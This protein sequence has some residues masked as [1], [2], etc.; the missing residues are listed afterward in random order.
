[1]REL[2]DEIAGRGAEVQAN[3]TRA[4]LQTLFNWAVEQ[5][6]VPSSPVAGLKPVAKEVDR[7]RVL[8]DDEIKWFWQSCD[9]V[10]WPF[11]P[12]FK[13]LLL[14]AQ[15]RD[16]VGTME[17]S[18]IDLD[19]RIWT[20]PRHKAKNNRVHEVQLSDAAI[21]LLGSLP[22][23]AVNSSASDRAGKTT[24]SKFVFTTNG[25]TPVSGFSRAKHRL[26]AIMV[27]VRRKSLNQPEA[28]E[29]HRRAL[30]ITA[31]GPLPGE[32]PAWILHDLRRTTATGMAKLNVPPHVVDK[33]LN[34]VSGAIRGVAAIYNRHGY[35]N[36][37]RDALEEWGRHVSRLIEAPLNNTQPDPLIGGVP[38]NPSIGREKLLSECPK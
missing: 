31:R 14:T 18:E 29:E 32:V 2:L 6:I 28:D 35:A 9:T 11:G 16:E 33:I 23:I 1:V 22:R 19:N 38:S 4:R 27:R 5:D 37:R 24:H 15:R 7:D 25:V 3:R 8:S 26:D 21:E 12:L 10:G 34:H 17:W 13:L 36:E 20:L 30:G